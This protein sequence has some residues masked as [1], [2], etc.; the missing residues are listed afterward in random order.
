MQLARTFCRYHLHR[1]PHHQRPP[2]SRP[3][4]HQRPPHHPH[5]PPH[6]RPPHQQHSHHHYS[7]RQEVIAGT[8]HWIRLHDLIINGE[9]A[10]DVS[11]NDMYMI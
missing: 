4:Y 11:S 9:L 10:P 3:P 1:P 6:S 7:R 8:E 5:R 2:H